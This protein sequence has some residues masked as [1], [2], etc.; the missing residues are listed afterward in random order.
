MA[1][2][3]PHVM[4][5]VAYWL[6]DRTADDTQKKALDFVNNTANMSIHAPPVGIAYLQWSPLI[7]SP[8]ITPGKP[9]TAVKDEN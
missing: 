1:D 8:Y 9:Y 2:Q 3:Q 5:T 6:R 7:D 4:K